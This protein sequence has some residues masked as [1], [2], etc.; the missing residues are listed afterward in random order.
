L[1]DDP[2]LQ[3]DISRGDNYRLINEAMANW[4]AA[5]TRDEALRQLEGARIPCGPVY[6]LDEVLADPQV[7]ARALLSP[8]AWPDSAKPVPIAAPA[9]RLSDAPGT[10]RHRAPLLGEHTDA[11]LRELGF[12]PAEIAAFRQQGIV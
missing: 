8:M 2:R 6:E 4:C 10:I 12:T 5:R 3:D 7:Q 9:V 1:I 11:I